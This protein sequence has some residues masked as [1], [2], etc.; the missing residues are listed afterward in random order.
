MFEII[1]DRFD[2]IQ[3]FHGDFVGLAFSNGLLPRNGEHGSVEPDIP[4]LPEPAEMSAP[5]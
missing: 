5:R 3:F 1:S 2:E 4:P